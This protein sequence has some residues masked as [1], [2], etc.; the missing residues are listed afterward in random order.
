MARRTIQHRLSTAGALALCVAACTSGSHSPPPDL[1][2]A[3]IPAGFTFQTTR[4]LDVTID[5]SSA[6]LPGSGEALLELARADGKRLFRGVL[7]AGRPVH[8]KL[9]LATKDDRISAV[10]HGDAGDRT[11]TLDASG[12][13]AT[14]SFAASAP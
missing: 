3:P 2:N 10:L 5:A 8:V 13:S 6:A 4:S 1:R 7:R 14:F 9:A 11:A 12:P